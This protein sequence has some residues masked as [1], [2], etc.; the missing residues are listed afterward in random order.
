MTPPVISLTVFRLHV[1]RW[2]RRGAEL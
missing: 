1:R 2:Q